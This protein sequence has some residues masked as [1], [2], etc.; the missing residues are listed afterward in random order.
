[1]VYKHQ[2]TCSIVCFSKSVVAGFR[3]SASTL[4]Q[5]L[6][7]MCLPSIVVNDGLNI[8]VD[9][10]PTRHGQHNVFSFVILRKS[11]AFDSLDFHMVY[12]SLC[13]LITR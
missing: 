13:L 8:E 1:M 10:P 2:D 11:F 3:E 7:K 12:V 5:L 6:T 9:I 4:A